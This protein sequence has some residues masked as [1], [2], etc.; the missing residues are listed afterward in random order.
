MAIKR[1]HPEKHQLWLNELE[2]LGIRPN[3]R[4]ELNDKKRS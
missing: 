1:E 3:K 2:S 4:N